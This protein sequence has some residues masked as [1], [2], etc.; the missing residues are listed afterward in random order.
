MIHAIILT[1]SIANA[2]SRLGVTPPAISNLLKETEERLEFS[3]FERVAGRLFPNERA[4]LIFNEI[5]RAFTGLNSINALC[6]QLRFQTARHVTLA[7]TPAFATAALPPAI[8]SFLKND[9]TVHFNL[10]NK[11]SDYVQ[12]LVASQKVD[13]GFALNLNP[14]PGVCSQLISRQELICLLPPE[15]SLASKDVVYAADLC[16]EPMIWPSSTEHIDELILSAFT[17]VGRRPPIAA[18]CPATLI[19]C[20]M[21]RC[22]LGFAIV[23]PLSTY[24]FR[25]SGMVMRPFM[26]EIQLSIH[27]FWVEER[28][29]PIE[30]QLFLDSVTDSVRTRLSELRI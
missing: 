9:S 12:A 23:D 13:L 10:M 26:P 8:K 24:L 5:E 2:A 18:E 20:E 25:H 3:L 27:A 16:D 11:P 21:V 14:L 15:H 30:R 19:A 28:K 1:G 22:S 6:S 7:S 17:S 4:Q 29:L